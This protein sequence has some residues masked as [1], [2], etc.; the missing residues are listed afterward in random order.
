MTNI[1][2]DG[3]S[4]QINQQNCTAN[5]HGITN[6][7]DNVLIPQTINYLDQKFIVTSISAA[8]FKSN[9]TIKT[10]TFSD[11]SELLSIDNYAFE[12]SS[13]E[14]IIIPPKV[15]K[16]GICAFSNCKNLRTIQFAVN[17]QLRTIDNNAFESSSIEKVIIPE[18]VQQIGVS[19]FKDC[20]KL[21]IVEFKEKSELR[22]IENFVF[23]S[24]SIENIIIP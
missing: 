23:N 11:D 12:S 21:K 3:I 7:S 13:I 14:A 5:V 10:I 19:A 18:H 22:T 2:H 6:S 20:I 4:Y 16:I 24:T 9:K 8:S 17:S 15:K 1:Q